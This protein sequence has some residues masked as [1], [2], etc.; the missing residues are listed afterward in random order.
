MCSSIH[1]FE[2]TILYIDKPFVRVRIF[3]AFVKE[4]SLI[5][6]LIWPELLSQ[7]WAEVGDGGWQRCVEERR[8]VWRRVGIVDCYFNIF[9]K[10][11][12]TVELEK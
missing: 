9:L 7:L 3:F 2:R 4:E 5:A 10:Q 1:K 11:I 8:G 12:L 6:H